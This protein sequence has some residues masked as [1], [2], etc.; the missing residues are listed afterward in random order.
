M[1]SSDLEANLLRELTTF[2]STGYL[3]LPLADFFT[4]QPKV[5]VGARVDADLPVT[6][7]TISLHYSIDPDAIE[8]SAHSSWVSVVADTSATTQ[9]TV[10]AEAAMSGV[11]SRYLTGKI[12]L[13][14]ST[15]ATTSP[16][17]Y[18][19]AFRALPIPVDLLMRLYV[20]VSDLVIMP[21]RKPI[22]VPEQGKRIWVELRDNWLG[23]NVEAEMFRP[24]IK[25]RGQVVNM[26]TPIQGHTERGT[27]Q[28]YA[29]LDV[30]GVR[31]S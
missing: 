4:N 27:A 25:I 11:K 3:I 1:C 14:P 24:S 2:A 31:V 16:V 5:W 22:K 8:N 17:V 6:Q 20:N 26:T 12:T 10:D 29:I 28:V 30:R 7:E 23:R 15:D 21:N 9:A 18:S 19:A 13:T